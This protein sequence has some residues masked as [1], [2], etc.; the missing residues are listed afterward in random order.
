M[1]EICKNSHYIFE[2]NVGQI[3]DNWCFGVPDFGKLLGI[4]TRWGVKL[5]DLE[6]TRFDA[7][8]NTTLLGVKVVI[9]RE[10]IWLKGDMKIVNVWDKNGMI[11][12]LGVWGHYMIG[13]H[14]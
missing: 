11:D 1:S 13:N 2:K 3:R 6:N 12:N 4:C 14:K 9:L 5:N 8:F 7:L 10:L